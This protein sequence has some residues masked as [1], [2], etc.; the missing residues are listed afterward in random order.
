MDAKGWD[1][2]YAKGQTWSVEPNRFFVDA[3]TSCGLASPPDGGRALDL[4]CGEGRNAVWLARQGWAVTAVDFSA[5]GIERGRQMAA[6]AGVTVDYVVADLQQWPIEPGAWDLIAHVYLHWPT[7]ERDPFLHSVAQGLAPGGYLIVIGHDRTNI[8]H[9]VGGPRDPDV[10][11]TPAELREQFT[12]FGL[13]VVEAR[14]VRREV[15]LE[16]GHGSSE[17][18][19]TVAHA[20]DHLVIARREH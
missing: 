20:I 18:T 16:P 8:E 1:E 4:A 7:A 12:G 11:S 6:D 10:L 15:A 13:T 5:V 3:V 19:A 2:R 14:E 9:G 17:A